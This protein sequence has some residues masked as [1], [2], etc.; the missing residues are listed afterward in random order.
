MLIEIL[1]PP[2]PQQ[3]TLLCRTCA[4]P[5]RNFR[6]WVRGGSQTQCW[7]STKFSE[8]FPCHGYRKLGTNCA[9]ASYRAFIRMLPLKATAQVH[10]MPPVF[11]GEETCE[12]TE[13]RVAQEPYN[14]S[15]S[16]PDS[17]HGSIWSQNAFSIITLLK[18]TNPSPHSRKE[19]SMEKDLQHMKQERLNLRPKAGRWKSPGLREGM[20]RT[21][22]GHT[23]VSISQA[24]SAV[25]S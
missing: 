11:L 23:E 5:L 19:Q 17:F 24:H 15:H 25:F 3:D 13:C 12:G 1:C 7:P 14:P 9:S 2:W 20:R 22:Q 16:L 21:T 4:R 8:T 10:L 18:C 6:G